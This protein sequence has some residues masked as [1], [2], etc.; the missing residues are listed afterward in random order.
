MWS[1]LEHSSSRS[2]KT[3]PKPLSSLVP[4]TCENVMI[5][6]QL[7]VS[8]DWFS[9]ARCKDRIHQIKKS[10]DEVL[11]KTVQHE[12]LRQKNAWVAV[13]TQRWDIS[14][15]SRILGENL[16][17]S[18]AQAVFSRNI[19]L[20]MLPNNHTTCTETN[21]KWCLLFIDFPRHL[22]KVSVSE[23]VV[24]NNNKHFWI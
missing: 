13:S 15:K 14:I 22:E 23:L 5:L 10:S 1:F 17:N 20:C 18:D 24:L 12:I 21:I 11:L 9:T 4:G 19:Q 7:E 3:E 16:L 8:E 2:Y 6:L